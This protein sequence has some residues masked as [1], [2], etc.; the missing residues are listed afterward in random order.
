MQHLATHQLRCDFLES[1]G[2]VAQ[3]LDEFLRAFV[4]P[5]REREA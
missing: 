2:F 3:S 4:S 5:Q 1:L